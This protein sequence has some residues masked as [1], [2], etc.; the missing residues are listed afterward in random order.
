MLDSRLI[1]VRRYASALTSLLWSLRAQ[2]IGDSGSA[3]VLLVVVVPTE[4]GS[5]A[6]LLDQVSRYTDAYV[7]QPS[8]DND[9]SHSSDTATSAAALRGRR[10]RGRRGKPEW[11]E[12]GQKQSRLQ[13][14]VTVMDPS[15]RDFDAQR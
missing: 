8:H 14:F 6:V 15:P 12:E 3:G 1:D 5:A 10:K 7:V 4:P 9:H 11:S 2:E 13:V